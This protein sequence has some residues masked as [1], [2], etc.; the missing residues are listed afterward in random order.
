MM[1]K[2]FGQRRM[3]AA[4][5]ERIE[6]EPVDRAPLVAVDFVAITQFADDAGTSDLRALS[7]DVLA[8]LVVERGEKIVERFPAAVAP[9]PVLPMEL[10]V[11]SGEPAGSRERL[12]IIFGDEVDVRGGESVALNLS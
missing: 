12:R 5:L 11:E 6:I 3:V 7:S 2:F 1:E 9:R 4:F 8:L 10:P